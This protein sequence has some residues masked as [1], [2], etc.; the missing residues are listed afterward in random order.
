MR[1]IASQLTAEEIE[2]LARYYAGDL[3]SL[4]AVSTASEMPPN[5]P[6]AASL[7]A[8]SAGVLRQPQ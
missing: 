5:A 1:F 7:R 6:C 2:R 8:A 3:A 4:P